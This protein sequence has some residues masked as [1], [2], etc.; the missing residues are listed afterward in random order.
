GNVACLQE[1]NV[2][3]AAGGLRDLH[4]LLW[5]A[6]A[7]YG[8]ADLGKL[9]SAEVITERDAR[10]VTAAYDFLLRV[11]NEMHF[12]TTRR[13][14]LL[15]LDLQQQVAR[16]FGYTDSSELQ[17]SESFMRD[18]YLHARRLHRLCEAH[19]QRAAAKQEKRRWFSRARTMPAPGGFVMRDGMLDLERV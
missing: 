18:Y 9:V 15:S 2:K 4:T 14:D 10:A 17:A 7:A 19:L 12:A 13:T 5:A 3:E 6:R 1:P 16:S 11:R 8:K